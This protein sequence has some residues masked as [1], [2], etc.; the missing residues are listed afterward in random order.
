M[1]KK[2]GLIIGIIVLILIITAILIMKPKSKTGKKI[3]DILAYNEYET[4]YTYGGNTY[5]KNGRCHSYDHEIEDCTR[6]TKT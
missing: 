1:K 5:D 2:L 6:E 3:E 4:Y